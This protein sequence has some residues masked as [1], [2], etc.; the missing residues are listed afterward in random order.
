M[1]NMKISKVESGEAPGGSAKA[2]DKFPA[3]L[4]DYKMVDT[5]KKQVGHCCPD[6]IAIAILSK[7][8]GNSGK[9][10]ELIGKASKVLSTMEFLFNESVKAN[11]AVIIKNDGPLLSFGDAA[12]GGKET[13]M[14]FER[15]ANISFSRAEI[16]LYFN[17]DKSI[18]YFPVSK[19]GFYVKGDLASVSASGK[20][21]F[22]KKAVFD[23]SSARLFL[24]NPNLFIV[25]MSDYKGSALAQ[26]TCFMFRSLRNKGFAGIFNAD[27]QYANRI[28]QQSGVNGGQFVFYALAADN[29]DASEKT[30]KSLVERK[31]TWLKIFDLAGQNTH[32]LVVAMAQAEA[33]APAFLFD[34][35]VNTNSNFK[36]MLDI[37]SSGLG[38]ELQSIDVYSIKS[39]DKAKDDAAKAA[40]IVLKYEDQI[41]SAFKRHHFALYLLAKPYIKDTKEV[42]KGVKNKEYNAKDAENLDF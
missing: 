23:I 7:S 29:A 6:E 34:N 11:G 25:E 22:D 39:E 21:W 26:N 27:R 3:V 40:A 42:L 8:G 2:T 33:Q 10:N 41:L 1:Q 36:M 28:M 12:Y 32:M 35:W 31:D 13:K 24:E 19:S 4:Y 17:D 38:K 20:M 9:M 16:S 14:T 30:A 18:R 37:L 5:I 15:F